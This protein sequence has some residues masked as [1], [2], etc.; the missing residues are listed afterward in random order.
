M[1]KPI[2]A[3]WHPNRC[4]MNIY[5]KWKM[6]RS[7]FMKFSVFVLFFH[8]SGFYLICLYYYWKCMFL[9]DIKVLH[10]DACFNAYTSILEKICALLIVKTHC[11]VWVLCLLKYDTSVCL[12]QQQ[13]KAQK[14][15]LTKIASHNYTCLSK[16]IN[17]ISFFFHFIKDQNKEPVIKIHV[18]A[19]VFILS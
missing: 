7:I 16:H 14:Y 1:F 3:S 6:M 2:T 19:S 10:M 5:I 13:P 15:Y 11:T 17:C 9:K 4:V 18:N 12:T 8:L